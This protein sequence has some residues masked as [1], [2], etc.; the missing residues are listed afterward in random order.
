MNPVSDKTTPT[1][2]FW[3]R[4]NW[5][6]SILTDWLQ[7]K[8]RVAGAETNL[9]SKHLGA[10]FHHAYH[11]YSTTWIEIQPYARTLHQTRDA[12]RILRL[13]RSHNETTC[14]RNG[15]KTNNRRQDPALQP[16][17]SRYFSTA[18]IQHH[19][20]PDFCWT[21]TPLQLKLPE[22]LTIDG[23]PPRETPQAG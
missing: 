18:I 6:W 20:M 2:D 23:S 4:P 19:A 14:Q 1:T 17:S 3:D 8:T 7:Q 10:T 21:R 15:E 22:K 16:A 13:D 11:L 9:C 5:K 12:Y